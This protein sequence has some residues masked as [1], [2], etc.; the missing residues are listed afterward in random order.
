MKYYTVIIS[1]TNVLSGD[2]TSLRKR[3]RMFPL[4]P[5]WN[6]TYI[7]GKRNATADKKRYLLFNPVYLNYFYLET[8][9]RNVAI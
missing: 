1:R 8:Y 4:T 3:D 5:K 7:K 6:S 2:R 9:G